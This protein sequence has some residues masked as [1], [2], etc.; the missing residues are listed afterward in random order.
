[1]STGITWPAYAKIIPDG[2][3]RGTEPGAER[4][5]LEGDPPGDQIDRA[6]APRHTRTVRWLMESDADATACIAWVVDTAHR[7]FDAPAPAPAG[8]RARLIDGP[9]GVTFTCQ[10]L[11][12]ARKRIWY[13]NAT[14]ETPA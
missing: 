11:D 7:W 10:V 13:G 2:E 9:A 14:L 8:T 12:S 6:T 1:M 3:E 4:T 5:D